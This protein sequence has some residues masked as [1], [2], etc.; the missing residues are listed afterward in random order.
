MNG[1]TSP[2]LSLA[3]TRRTSH[4]SEKSGDPQREAK[5]LWSF[6]AACRWGMA[7]GAERRWEAGK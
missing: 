1:P 2:P 7:V 6:T 4:P 5:T 3:G